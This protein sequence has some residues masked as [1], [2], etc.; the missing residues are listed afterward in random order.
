M[1]ALSAAYTAARDVLFNAKD[2][3]GNWVNY[4]TN[5]AIP[6]SHSNC[7]I[8]IQ[9][10][11]PCEAS[12]EQEWQ[13]IT[14]AIKENKF[15]N[16]DHF[17]DTVVNFLKRMHIELYRLE[18]ELIEKLVKRSLACFLVRPG[19]ESTS[20]IASGVDI[21]RMFKMVECATVDLDT[22]LCFKA[23]FQAG[24]K[25]GKLQKPRPPSKVNETPYV[26]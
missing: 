13:S 26:F 22:P 5:F 23:I 16:P 8:T 15:R 3:T 17:A 2:S 21:T 12:A 14:A 1:A 4:A 20:T 24:V 18:W 6:L 19:I 10:F 11:A 9:I 25:L 7:C